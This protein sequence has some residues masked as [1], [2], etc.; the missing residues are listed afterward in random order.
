MDQAKNWGEFRIACHYTNIPGENRIWADTK[1]NIGWQ[2]VGIAPIRENF[3]GLVQC[4][5]MKHIKK[6]YLDVILE[7]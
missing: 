4:R 1:G 2:A 5:K 6:R 7:R 3:S